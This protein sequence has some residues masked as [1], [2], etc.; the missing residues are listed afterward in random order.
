MLSH[1]EALVG[2]V[3]NHRVL[4]QP[5]V[6]KILNH[7]A[8]IAVNGVNH[9]PVV[10][11]VALVFPFGQCLSR[12]VRLLEFTD[13]GVVVGI[14][15]RALR[16]CHAHVVGASPFFQQFVVGMDLVLMVGHL[17]V[18][19][20]IHILDDAHL[21]FLCGES[22][23]IVVV[24]VVGQGI[25]HVVIKVEVAGVRVPDAVRS[26][27][28][29]QETEGLRLVALVAHPVYGEVGDDVG[30][31]SLSLYFLAIVDERRIIVVALSGQDVP[32]VEAGG[33]ARQMPFAHDASLVAGLLQQLWEGLLAAV[34]GTRVVGESVF[35]A[36]LAGE[37]TGA[38]G[39]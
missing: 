9:A 22:S 3:D 35:M 25:N 16:R 24:E 5:V 26:L 23:L 10:V 12:E 33:I 4:E 32:V 18:V 14:P 13:D 19:D 31:V 6:L 7:T 8:H 37:Q 34:E 38:R 15:L 29:E 11:H 2:G 27:V 1:I 17:Q 28:V 21:L 39:A 20:D 30:D 36:V